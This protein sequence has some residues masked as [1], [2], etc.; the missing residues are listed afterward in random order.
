M[1][2][3]ELEALEGLVENGETLEVVARLRGLVSRASVRAASASAV[4]ESQI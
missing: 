1:L 2:E 3:R 4:A